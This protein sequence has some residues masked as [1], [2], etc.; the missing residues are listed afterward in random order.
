MADNKRG[1][2]TVTITVDADEAITGLKALQR[3]LRKTTKEVRE[4][5]SAYKDATRASKRLK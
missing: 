2:L 4:L 1:D 3:E 5:E